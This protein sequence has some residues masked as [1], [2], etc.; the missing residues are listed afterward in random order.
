MKTNKCY[1]PEIA[2]NASGIAVCLEKTMGALEQATMFILAIDPSCLPKGAR[3][4]LL[5]AVAEA[6]QQ[7]RL[8]QAVAPQVRSR[9]A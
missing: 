3:T 4:A 5:E 6:G 2:K 8:T 9:Q 7:V 1:A